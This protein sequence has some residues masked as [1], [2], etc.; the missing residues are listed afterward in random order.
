MCTR[1]DI[2]V[3]Y[4]KFKLHLAMAGRKT[5]RYRYVDSPT[6]LSASEIREQTEA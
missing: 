2:G 4:R 5:Y 1:A 3:E 6:A